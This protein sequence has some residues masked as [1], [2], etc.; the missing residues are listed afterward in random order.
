M[1]TPSVAYG[2]IHL[3]SVLE[4][5]ELYSL[6]LTSLE[7]GPIPTE[8]IIEHAQF[9]DWISIDLRGIFIIT[10]HGKKCQAL[11]HTK[12][13]LR[14]L[15]KEYFA[16]RH[17]PW[18][19]LAK[20]GRGPV[21]MQSPPEILQLF[22]EAGLAEDLDQ[23]TIDFWDELAAL[24]RSQTDTKNLKTGRIGEKMSMIFETNRTGY[25]PKWAAIESNS[26]GYDVLTR[27]SS[28]D[29]THLKIEV[30]C[31]LENIASA[32]FH[33][34]KFEWQV[35]ER[36][37]NY[38]FHIWSVS[39]NTPSLAVLTVAQVEPHIPINQNGGLWE[40]VEIPFKLFKFASK[41]I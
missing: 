23:N 28:T 18:L 16:R 33:L 21:L 13:Q 38:N 8:I 9:L 19:Q 15:L 1:L 6:E 29:G 37:N 11:P 35:A 24:V 12:V 39:E 41:K 40:T 14:F 22:H 32:R 5:Q 30:K 2:C 20:M 36:S 3:L 10:E 7:L 31:S 27:V 25:E 26:Y 4:Q 17:D 34:T